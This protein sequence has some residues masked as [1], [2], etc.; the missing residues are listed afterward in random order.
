VFA[1]LLGIVVAVVA[2]YYVL[3][4][5]FRIP[6]AGVLEAPGANDVGP[7]DEGRGAIE[8][9]REIEFDRATGKLSESDY[10]VLKERY[11][12]AAVAAMR[13]AD[14]DGALADNV[15]DDAEALVA[16]FRGRAHVC[17][18]CGPRPES[19]AVFCSNC[20][21]F[22]G[23]ACGRCGAKPPEPG[24]RYCSSCGASLAA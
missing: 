24:A 6:T 21:R 12:G 13:G 10:A 19:D 9:L 23:G 18:E 11:T 8:A 22:L 17:A 3:E 15:A 16:R 7:P 20:G 14:A 1:L 5:L 4:P 2:L